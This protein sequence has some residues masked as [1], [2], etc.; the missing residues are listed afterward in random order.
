MA[1]GIGVKFS[2]LNVNC[3]QASYR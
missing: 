2:S 1:N 3:K